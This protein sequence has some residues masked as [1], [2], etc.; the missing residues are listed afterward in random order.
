MC[1]TTPSSPETRPRSSASSSIPR[2]SARPGTTA[3]PYALCIGSVQGKT[4]SVTRVGV[5]LGAGGVTGDA[6][7][8]GVL[9]ALWE[10]GYDARTADV[11]VGTSAGSMVGAF[12]RRP[13]RGS[14]RRPGR[15]TAPATL[16]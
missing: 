4:A 2:A 8:R 7:H 6:F 14:E 13:E 15:S 11:I 16:A 12:L 10:A 9:R 5:V 3:D 1:P